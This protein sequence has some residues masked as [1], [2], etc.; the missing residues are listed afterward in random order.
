MP[1]DSLLRSP[2]AKSALNGFLGGAAGGAMVSAFTNKKSAKKL[3]KAGGLVALGGV[4][5]SA[6]QKYRD[7]AEVAPQSDS[8]A[9]P[10]PQP[11]AYSGSTAPE[12]SCLSESTLFRAMAAAAHADG[13]IDTAEQNKIWQEALDAGV[14]GDA[15]NNL[16]TLLQQPPTVE[17]VLAE[18]TNME[19]KLEIYTASALVIDDSCEQ[20]LRY[21][22]H[23]KHKLGLPG[24]LTNAVDARI[25][26]AA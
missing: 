3:L 7:G 12:A 14:D 1:I 26:Q 9:T 2:Q 4:A 10:L 17:D 16:E 11:T 18:A 23:L 20:G 25:A 21:L 13:H 5:W 8:N 24:A 19:S 22:D 15:L 6:Y